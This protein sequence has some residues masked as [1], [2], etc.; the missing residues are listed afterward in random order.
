MTAEDTPAATPAGHDASRHEGGI[1]PSCGSPRAHR[2]HRKG[3]AERL[4]SIAGAKMRRCH[5]CN[6]RYATLW[7][8]TIYIDDARRALR[9]AAFVL[10]MIVGTLIVLATMMWLMNKQAAFTPTE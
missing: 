5:A 10:L 7:H 9:R 8:S 2:S 3:L 4:L 6:I 1:C